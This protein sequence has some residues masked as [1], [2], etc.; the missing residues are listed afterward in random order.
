MVAKSL[1]I[2]IIMVLAIY[3]QMNYSSFLFLFFQHIGKDNKRR[4]IIKIC[5]RML[6]YVK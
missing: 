1:E 3:F 4:L 6:A 5:I 2:P